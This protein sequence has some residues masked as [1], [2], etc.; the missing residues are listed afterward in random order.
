MLIGKSDCFN[1][2][3]GLALV[4]KIGSLQKIFLPSLNSTKLFV[5]S[6]ASAKLRNFIPLFFR[7]SF[8]MNSVFL[9]NLF[10]TEEFLESRIISLLIFFFF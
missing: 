3:N 10:N 2:S 7:I 5:I 6:L 9:L 4:A 8:A 1:K